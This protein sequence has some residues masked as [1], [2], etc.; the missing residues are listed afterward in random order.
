M[1]GFKVGTDLFIGMKNVTL[2]DR[3]LYQN[4]F[5]KKS[6]RIQTD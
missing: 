2:G 4:V 3:S 1:I 6:T 5:I